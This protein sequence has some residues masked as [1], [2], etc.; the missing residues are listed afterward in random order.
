[1][2]IKAAIFD[3]DGTIIDSN[4]AHVAAWDEAFRHFGKEFSGEKLRENIGKGADKYLPEFLNREELN[5]LG[6]KIDKYRSEVFKNKYRPHL[7]PFPKVRELFERIRSDGKRIALASSGKKSDVKVM[8]EIARIQDL[9][10]CEITA[11][12]ADES[13]PAPDIFESTLQKLGDLPASSVIAIG[14]TPFDAKAAK[15][16]GIATVGVLCGGFSADEL[17]AAGVI[18]SYRDPA[19]LLNQYE[20]SPI[21]R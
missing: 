3:V 18:A 12:D 8:K 17:R 11:D 1:M 9:V 20:K 10:D 19:D 13:K 6:D 21:A 16:V 7:Q 15:K 14:D 5:T 4:D 2:E